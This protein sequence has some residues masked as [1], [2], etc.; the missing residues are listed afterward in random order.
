MYQAALKGYAT[1][2]D[3]A[4]YLVR[5]QVPFRD[6]H[7]IVGNTVQYAI[8]Q[9]KALSDLN[10]QELQSFGAMIDHT[11]YDVLTLEGSANSRDHFGGTAP[12]QVAHALD[13][14]TQRLN[15]K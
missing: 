11:V 6:A 15:D 13:A 10:L 3:L 7:E 9:G 4:E 8:A 12:K 14:A 2:T 5:L 1:A